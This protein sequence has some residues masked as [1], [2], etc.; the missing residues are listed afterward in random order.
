MLKHIS[1][2]KREN[3]DTAYEHKLI[4]VLK[5]IELKER[6]ARCHSLK[7]AVAQETNAA[8]NSSVRIRHD[9]M[10]I[11]QEKLAVKCQTIQ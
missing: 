4:T 7:L 11:C 3:K 10:K 8:K 5:R 1:H 9:K 6:I 2:K